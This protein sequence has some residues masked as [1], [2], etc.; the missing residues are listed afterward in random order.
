MKRTLTIIIITLAAMAIGFCSCQTRGLTHDQRAAQRKLR[1]A[2]E[3]DPDIIAKQYTDTLISG[4]VDTQ[5]AVVAEAFEGDTESFDC[6]SLKKVVKQL[7]AKGDDAG[8]YLHQDSLIDIKVKEDANGKLSVKYTV[9][10]R[11]IYKYI[12]VPYAK[13]I[14]VPGKLVKVYVNDKVWQHGWFW[15]I[16]ILCVLLTALYLSSA[17]NYSK[18]KRVNDLR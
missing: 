12:R 5:V 18:L 1:K 14:S 7:K 9:K 11:I 8:V 6:D 15:V 3:K 13:V 4:Y 17:R 2:I 16:T 10:D